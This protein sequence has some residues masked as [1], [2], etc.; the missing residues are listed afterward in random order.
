MCIWGERDDAEESR[1]EYR[2]RYKREHNGEEPLIYPGE[3]W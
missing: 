1:E 2:A 3:T